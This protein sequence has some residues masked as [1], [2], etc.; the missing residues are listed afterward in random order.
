MAPK[1]P[2][3]ISGKITGGVANTTKV[4]IYNSIGT[5]VEV[6]VDGS[7]HYVYDL[8]NFPDGFLNGDV[9]F[10]SNGKTY[11]DK[12]YDS[13]TPGY[14]HKYAKCIRASSKLSLQKGHTYI[15][16]DYNLDT[17]MHYVMNDLGNVV[18]Y[19]KKYFEEERSLTSA[20][21]Q[22]YKRY[23]SDEEKDMKNHFITL[24]QEE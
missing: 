18:S 5:Y 21:Q 16:H 11:Y 19:P 14:E 10:F 22:A 20:E 7:L 23:L 12:T 1:T 8:A 6:T 24:Q 2:Y 13:K 15:I 4:R 3:L 17:S 9:F